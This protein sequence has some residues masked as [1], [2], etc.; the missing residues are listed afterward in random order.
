MLPP[1]TDGWLAGA[2]VKAAAL[3]AVAVCDVTNGFGL[4]VTVTVNVDPVHDP[5]T[6]VTV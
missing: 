2:T 5:D 6:G 3:H 1:T 4:T